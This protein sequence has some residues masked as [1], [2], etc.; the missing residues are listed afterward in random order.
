MD[1][2]LPDDEDHFDAL[3][4]GDA[5]RVDLN[6]TESETEGNSNCDSVTICT[7]VI[8]RVDDSETVQLDLFDSVKALILLL[9]L[10]LEVD[11]PVKVSEF[12][13]ALLDLAVDDPV[14]GRVE[15]IVIV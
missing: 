12:A 6:E 10:K 9:E 13:Y 2:A 3:S 7:S 15:V 5:L 11:D 8:E 14:S 1:G 4:E